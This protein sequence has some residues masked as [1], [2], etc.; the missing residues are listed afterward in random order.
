LGAGAKLLQQVE[1]WAQLA[2]GIIGFPLVRH[3]S[4]IQPCVCEKS[5]FRRMDG[6]LHDLFGTPLF[7]MEKAI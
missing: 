6:G 3:P 4:S 2:K 5:G 7:T 1:D